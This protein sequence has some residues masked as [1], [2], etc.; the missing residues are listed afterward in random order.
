MPHHGIIKRCAN[1]PTAA[2][3]YMNITTPYRATCSLTRDCRRQ[4][5]LLVTH[6]SVLFLPGKRTNMH[7]YLLYTMTSI[8]LVTLGSMKQIRRRLLFTICFA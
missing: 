8:H 5:G 6:A 7:N 3:D 1:A 2:T 4:V